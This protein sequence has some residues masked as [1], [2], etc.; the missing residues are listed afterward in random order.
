MIIFGALLSYGLHAEPK[1]MQIQWG[2]VY[3][4]RGYIVRLKFPN[5]DIQDQFT[6]TNQV[7]LTLEPGSYEIQV[8]GRNAFG[9]PGRFSEWRSLVILETQKSGKLDLSSNRPA[10]YS[11]EEPGA[12]NSYRWVYYWAPIPVFLYHGYAEKLRGD[13][14]ARDPWNDPVVLFFAFQD[15]PIVEGAWS[16][17]RRDKERRKYNQA[18]V[19]QKYAIAGAGLFL[20]AYYIDRAIFDEKGIFESVTGLG[21]DPVAFPLMSQDRYMGLQF[22]K[23][24]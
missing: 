10:Q 4:S 21:Q 6:E 5:G 12:Q 15:R 23:G 16:R 13:A 19:R 2:D 14:L 22:S 9:K 18:Q 1:K 3:G 7:D 20:L 24:F 11:Q 8:A 17:H